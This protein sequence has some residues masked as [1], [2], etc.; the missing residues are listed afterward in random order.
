MKTWLFFCL[1]REGKDG[2]PGFLNSLSY[3]TCSCAMYYFGAIVKS[4]DVEEPHRLDLGDKLHNGD[5]HFGG[6]ANTMKISTYCCKPLL[7]LSALAF[8]CPGNFS[9]A[10]SIDATP[11]P[12]LPPPWADKPSKGGGGKTFTHT[13]CKRTRFFLWIHCLPPFCVRYLYKTG[14]LSAVVRHQR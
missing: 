11:T 7:F 10:S 12:A 13:E 9:Y 6:G 3:A 4:L 2:E 14:Q 1:F 8:F 5:V